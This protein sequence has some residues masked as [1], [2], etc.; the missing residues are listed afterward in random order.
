MGK[1]SLVAE[2]DTRGNLGV[3]MPASA[4]RVVFCTV[5]KEGIHS[6]EE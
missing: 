3:D 1:A 5:T 6:C 4:L 2:S